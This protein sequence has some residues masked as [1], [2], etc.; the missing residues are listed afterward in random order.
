ML[1]AVQN[2]FRLP[3]LR[4]KIL[5]TLGILTIYRFA[6]HIPVPGIDRVALEQFF[7]SSAISQ[8]YNL[9]S[10][11]ALANFSI[12]AMGVYPYIT[13]SII[14]Q[15]L[16]PLVPALEELSKEGE[17]GRKRLDQY[18]YWLT[19]PLA[20]LQGLGQVAIMQQAQVFS[21]FGFNLASIAT[22]MSLTAGT[23]FAIWLGELITERGIGNGLSIII[24]GGILAGA[25]AS[26]AQLTT[27]EQG[28]LQLVLFLLIMVVTVFAIVLIQQGERRIPVKYKRQ[29]RGR[30]QVGGQSNYIPLRVNASGM[31]PIILAQ[32]ILLFPSLIAGYLVPA[33]DPAN[34][35]LFNAV[36]AV[37]DFFSP[38]SAFYWIAY[39]IMVV[40]FTYFYTDIIFRQ[41]NVAESLRR[42]GGVIEGYR[43]GKPTKDY[44]QRVMMRITLVGALFLGVLA[45]LA[46]LVSLP[47]GAF[48]IP[49]D[50][51]SGDN[52]SFIISSVGLLIVVGVVLDTMRQ[53]EA[54]LT[55]RHYEKFIGR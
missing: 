32:S 13:A 47:L 43:E 33:V 53:L 50:L 55:M 45:I 49:L 1:Q 35:T 39:F 2:A 21:D 52:G 42:Q 44:L 38:T 27:G 20:F 16:T 7:Q 22:L 37:R 23:M 36:V 9:L 12:L 54:Q 31:I 17:Q 48:G 29:V 11:G 51:S 19:V 5:F 30:R 4:Y 26:I 15:L 14:F 28:L 8:F 6:A 40:G 3:D 46:W 41:Q 34:T 24:F 10:G 25:P 18:T